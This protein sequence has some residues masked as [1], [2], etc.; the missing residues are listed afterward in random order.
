MGRILNDFY[1]T[2]DYT[3]KSLLDLCEIPDN[4]T[5][6]EPCKGNGQIYNKVN[7]VSIKLYSELTEGLNYL[8]TDYTVSE[9]DLIIT[10]PPY[11]LAKEFLEKSLKE[12]KNV[13]YLLRLGFL[14]SQSRK[15]WWNKIGLP[16]KL[17]ILSKRPKFINNT[18]DSQEYAW[19]CW[20]RD[21][22]IKTNNG[23]TII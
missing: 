1:P 10:N 21:D 23:I 19:F 13:F 3:I 7:N 20:D 11:S 22:I 9:I 12:S 2:P 5:F 15:D 6:L 14:A 8:T 18:S 17:L 4:F 16:N